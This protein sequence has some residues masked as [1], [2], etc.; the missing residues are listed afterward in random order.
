MGTSYSIKIVA[1]PADVDTAAVQTVIDDVLARIDRSMSAYRGDSEISR[2]NASHSTEWFE[3]SEDLANVVQAALQFSEDSGGAF[4]VTVAPLVAAWGFGTAERTP[5]SLPEPAAL[6]ALRAS[7][8][9][10]KLQ[11]RMRPPALRKTLAEV[12]ID[13]NAIAPGYAVDQLGGRFSSL[14]IKRYMINI[15]GEIR[16]QGSNA[17]GA[18]WKIAVERPVD[19]ETIPYA[20]IGLSNL[21]IT[22]SGEYRR[23]YEIDGRRYSHTLDPRT[24]RPVEHSLASVAVIGPTSMYTDG[25]A[26]A[27]NVLGAQAGYDLAM[28]RDIAAMFIERR[29]GRLRWRATPD[30]EARLNWPD[31]DE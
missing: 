9:Y 30:F 16:V 8:G 19:G 29:D 21:A 31:I 1:P 24:G 3:V 14:G 5:Q 22:V 26:T 10:E 18:V 27:L 20:I 2:F 25:W 6:D 12:Q 17:Q 28:Q 23:Y 7:T 13:L 4:D 15:G 11:V